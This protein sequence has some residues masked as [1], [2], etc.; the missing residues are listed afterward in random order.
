MLAVLSLDEDRGP[1]RLELG[2]SYSSLN[3]R[4]PV[5]LEGQAPSQPS[6]FQFRKGT[7]S[8]PWHGHGEVITEHTEPSTEGALPD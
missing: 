2:G 3:Q 1:Q 6:H 7:E 5:P 4:S 8:D